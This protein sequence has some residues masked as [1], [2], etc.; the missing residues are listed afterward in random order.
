MSSV[1]EVSDLEDYL[2]PTKMCDSNTPDII[3][4]AGNLTKMA[5][6]DKEKAMAIFDYVRDEIDFIMDPYFQT[7]SNTLKKGIGFCVGKS[8]LQIA[9]LRAIKIPARYHIVHLDKE[10]L[11]PFLLAWVSKQFPP[12]IDHHP[13][14]ECYLNGKWVACDTTFDKA[15]IEGAKKQGY[16]DPELFSQL[17]WDGENDLNIFKQWSVAEVGY[18]ANLDEFWQDTI[19]RCYSPKFMIKFALFFANKHLRSIRN[20]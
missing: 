15:F 10:C 9:M 20:H 19:K 18:F 1:K 17:D 11:D 3:S 12:I 8:N 4:K 14:C 5:L 13:I 16:L 6:T 2:K 7:A